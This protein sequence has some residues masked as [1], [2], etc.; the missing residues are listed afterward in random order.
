MRYDGHRRNERVVSNAY[1]VTHDGDGYFWFK[2]YGKIGVYLARFQPCV[3][4]E[5][6]L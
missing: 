4:K 6:M 2:Q 5:P 3:L 1:L